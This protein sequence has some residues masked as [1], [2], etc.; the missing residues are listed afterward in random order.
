MKTDAFKRSAV[1]AAAV[2]LAV[3]DQISKNLAQAMLKP[4]GGQPFTVIPGLLELNY[5]ENPAAAFGLFGSVIWLVTALTLVVAGAIVALLFLYKRHS[6][7]S[8]V[9]SALLLAGGVGNLIDRIVNGYV[10]D[11]IH[12]MFFGY[13][14][15]VADC[16]VT[17]GS[18]FLV[19]HYL[20][21]LHQEKKAGAEAE[22]SPEGE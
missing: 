18:C 7:F 19:A 10:V 6:V 5:L 21:L 8:Y 9:A 2:L 16:C 4:N 14:F 22:K 12:V 20:Y 17:V 15:N 11:F 3:L 13:I 1:L